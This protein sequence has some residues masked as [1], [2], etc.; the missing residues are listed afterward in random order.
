MQPRVAGKE[1]D[2]AEAIEAWEENINRLAR[3]GDDYKMPEKS[4]N[5]VLTN[6]LVG[7][8]RDNFE[9]WEFETP[10]PTF[11]DLLKRVK[12]QARSKNLE[13]DVQK[14]GTGISLGANQANNPPSGQ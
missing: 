8:L 11:E 13:R 14:G 1:E 3:H 4:E 5:V 6:I 9:Q 10:K 7:K 12:D 2:I